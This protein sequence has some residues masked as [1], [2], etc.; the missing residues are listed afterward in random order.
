MITNAV[1]DFPSS[2]W[3]IISSDHSPARPEPSAPES[4]LE[5]CPVYAD[6]VLGREKDNL[7][8]GLYR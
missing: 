8:E 2:L 4:C 6:M 1:E 5:I 3:S 7:G